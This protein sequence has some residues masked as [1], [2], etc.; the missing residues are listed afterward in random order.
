MAVIQRFLGLAFLP[1]VILITWQTLYPKSIRA[2]QDVVQPYLERTPLLSALFFEKLPSRYDT[3][4]VVTAFPHWSHYEKIAKIAVVLADLGYPI[5]FITG[6]IFENEVKALHTNITFWPIY[7]K[8]DKMTPEDYKMLESFVPGSAEQN[9][10]MQ[11]KTLIDGIPDQ[12]LTLEQVFKDFRE[13]HGD[14]KPLISMFDLP[15]V[16]H[17]PIL[18]GAPGIKPDASIAIG[19][20]PLML[21]SN[22]TF[23]LYMSKRPHV[24][25]DAK[26]VHYKANQA[27]HMDFAT[28]HLSEAYWQKIKE[29]GATEVRGWHIYHALNALP[30]H[31]MA[32]GVP[33]FE[34]PRNDLR[35]NVNYFGGLKT[36]PAPGDRE[37][38]LPYWW[39]DVAAAKVAGKSIV[40]VSQGTVGLNLNDLLIPTLDALKHRDDILV[41]AT[42][43]A[44]EVADVP[45]LV[46][47]SN[48]R[49]AKFVP[50]DLL[51]PQVLFTLYVPHPTLIMARSTSWS[52]TAVT[53]LSSAVSKLAYPW[54]WQVK[55]KTRTLQTLSW[56]GKRLVLISGA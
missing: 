55:G 37:S 41:I 14:D 48:A 49:V 20:H 9:L 32:L 42:T 29:V 52:T 34:F 33:E 31:L 36:K 12:Q 54:S 5:T 22:D 43:V 23:P 44:V 28:R 8:P 18:L 26:A 39:D 2:V 45:G 11:K 21:N 50:Y 38:E 15:F 19:C 13:R 16:G 35:A 47:P 6:R 10:F 46:I 4:L 7:G 1:I 40:A 53:A 56:R 25:P 17:H 30:E 3:P 24:G 27:E 51:L